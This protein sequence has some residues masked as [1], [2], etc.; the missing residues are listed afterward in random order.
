MEFISGVKQKETV[1][2]QEIISGDYAGKTVRMEGS[3][4]TIRDMGDVAFI[5]LRKAE[6][7]VQCVFEDGKTAFDLNQLKEES[8][9]RVTG[10]V[11]GEERAP[12]GF[13]IRLQEITVLSQPAEVLPIAISKWKLKTSLETKLGLRP[14]T[15]RNP[16]ERAKFRIQEGI[17]RGFRIF[18]IPRILPKSVHQRL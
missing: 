11:S 6:G 3:V 10:V 1:G 12:H 16:M 7:L 15:L 14:I 9:I 5:I 4:H 13:E 17:V 18:F 8:A 2:I